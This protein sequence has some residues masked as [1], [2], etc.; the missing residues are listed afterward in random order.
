MRRLI[1]VSAAAAILG[2]AGCDSPAQPTSRPAEGGASGAA[3]L[4]GSPADAATPTAKPAGTDAA[5][6]DVPPLNTTEFALPEADLAKLNVPARA[7]LGQLIGSMKENPTDD[8][9]FGTLGALYWINAAPEWSIRAYAR[10]MALKPTDFRWPYLKSFALE[11]AG[12][13]A[14]ALAMVD[15]ALE[16]EPNYYPATQRRAQ[17]LIKIDPQKAGV[18]LRA[19]LDKHPRDALSAY[20][21]AQVAAAQKDDKATI[22]WLKRSIEIQND[23][24]AANR[25][26]AKLLEAA[27]DT[28]GAADCTRRA[29]RGNAPVLDDGVRWEAMVVGL[30]REQVIRAALNQA[31]QRNFAEADKSLQTAMQ[32]DPTA[33]GVRRALA[34]VRAMQGKTEEAVGVLQSLLMTDP[35]DASVRAQLGDLL[36]RMKRYDESIVE[37]RKVLVDVPDD[38]RVRLALASQLMRTN[39]NDEAKAELQAVIKADPT[40][41]GAYLALADMARNA[42]DLVELERLLRQCLKNCPQSTMGLNSLAWL[43]ATS[44]NAGQRNGSEAVELSERACKLVGFGSHEFIDTYATALAAVSR[45]DEAVQQLENAIKLA[46]AEG[47]QQAVKVYRD[48]REQFKQKRPFIDQ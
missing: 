11:K 31:E 19:C 45:F 17:L 5:P 14:G 26:L 2:I 40:F 30:D 25:E 8:R 35:K 34:S 39:K 43:L 32:M 9:L 20:G 21:L 1:F 16:L 48:R 13:A 28:A 23:F 3:K 37:L 36:G 10:A 4:G 6:A 15:K 12:D 33:K 7:K 38:S 42:R 44:P 27:G 29:A 41:D 22:E 47:K 46:I 24:A 18:A